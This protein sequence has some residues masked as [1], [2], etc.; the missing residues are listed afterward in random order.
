M[1]MYRNPMHKRAEHLTVLTDIFSPC[2]R[3][4]GNILPFSCPDKNLLL[5]KLRAPKTDYFCRDSLRT[6]REYRAY[7]KEDETGYRQKEP[8]SA[9]GFG[10]LMHKVNNM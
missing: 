8:F 6:T 1:Y 2:G 10:S 7:F 5:L 9:S 3:R 4:F